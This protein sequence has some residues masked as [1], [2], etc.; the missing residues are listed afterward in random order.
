VQE[1]V[2]PSW[3]L[4]LS[5]SANR[6]LHQI[7][8]PIII[9]CFFGTVVERHPEIERLDFDPAIGTGSH[10]AMRVTVDCRAEDEA[11]LAFWERRNIGAA[12]SE[13]NP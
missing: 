11:S 10:H 3:L 12:A 7:K 13:A 1:K 5:Y 9:H 6:R 2:Y 4:K 8:A